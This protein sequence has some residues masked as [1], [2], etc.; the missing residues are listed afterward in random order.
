MVDTNWQQDRETQ[1]TLEQLVRQHD[2]LKEEYARLAKALAFMGFNPTA[3]AD[4]L[5]PGGDPYAQALPFRMVTATFDEGKAETAGLS[6]NT[7]AHVLETLDQLRMP[8]STA[9]KR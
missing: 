6:D 5:R 4:Q 3:V 2:S 9:M 8:A 1:A 7:K